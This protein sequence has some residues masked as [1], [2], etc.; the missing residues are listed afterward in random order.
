MAHFPVNHPLRPIYRAIAALVG[1]YL[2]VIGLVLD[3][4]RSLGAEVD[5]QERADRAEATDRREKELA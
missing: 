4:L 2:I 1:V 3:I 5:R